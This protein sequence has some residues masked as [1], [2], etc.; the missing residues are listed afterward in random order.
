MNDRT[1]TICLAIQR[2][3]QECIL[4]DAV[5]YFYCNTA[6]TQLSAQKEINSYLI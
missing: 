1:G 2:Q 3:F 4:L 5:S 6:H